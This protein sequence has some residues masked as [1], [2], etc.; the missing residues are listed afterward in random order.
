MNYKNYFNNFYI[1]AETKKT[2]TV[3]KKKLTI[4]SSKIDVKRLH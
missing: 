4:K 2:N 3:T 1:L